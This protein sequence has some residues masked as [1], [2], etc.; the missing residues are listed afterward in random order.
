MT[1]AQ[2]S[3]G[4]RAGDADEFRPVLDIVEPAR[5]RRLTVFFRLLLLIPHAVVLFF[6]E[7]AAFFTLVFG[8]FAALALAR[9]PGPVYRFL[10][11]VLAYRTRVGASAMLLVDSYPPFSLS[12]PPQ[13]PVHIDVR[14]TR[15]NRLAVFFRLF[16]VI[17]AAIVQGLVTSGWSAL[18][19]LWW[20]ITLVLGRMPRP[21]FEA[22]A[23][24]LRYEMRV[25][26]YFSLLSPAYPKDLF[27]DD[28]L[29]V[30]QGRPRSATRPLV[31]ST[32]GKALIVLFLVLGL[33]GSVTTSVT[34]SSSD[35]TEYSAGR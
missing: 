26:A 5:Q 35:E 15:L 4:P 3:P 11:Q 32:G 9:L 30:P 13:Y 21:L 12:Q 27:G 19:V 14:P 29:S 33:L 18:A 22:T 28:A 7:I 20:L 25:S 34:R 31:M 24:T 8:W 10:A 1:D 23:A 17:P 6:L 16:L 2:W